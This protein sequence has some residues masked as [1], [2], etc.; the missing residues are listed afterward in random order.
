MFRPCWLA[1][2]GIVLLATELAVAQATDKVPVAERVIT[3]ETA[4]S[5]LAPFVGEDGR[6][7]DELGYGRRRVRSRAAGDRA[8]GSAR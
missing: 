2:V 7:Y 4:N 5:Q 1:H 8:A 3:V 6:L